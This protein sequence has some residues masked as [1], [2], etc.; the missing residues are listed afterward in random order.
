MLALFIA[1]RY[2]FSPKSHAVVNRI[3]ALSVAAVAMPVAAMIVLLSV[4]NG[5]EGLVRSMAT[6]FDADL[7]VAPRR[8]VVFRM[9]ELDTAALRAVPGVEALSFV[10]EQKTLLERDGRQAAVTIRGVDDSYG[11]VVP[12]AG[13]VVSGGYGV[14]TGDL[15]RLVLGQ[16]MAYRLGIRSL[17]DADVTIYA[18]RRGS[19]SSLLPVGNFARRTVP[20]GGVFALDMETEQEFVLGWIGW[21]RRCSNIP[22]G[23]PHWCCGSRPAPTKRR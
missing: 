17:A 6:V 5:F 15:E 13:T 21:G 14:R 19:F 23:P 7:T 1:R 3:A 11:E 9:Q 2:L 10:L 4:F 20:A 22:T 12:V 8:G 18:L 16:T